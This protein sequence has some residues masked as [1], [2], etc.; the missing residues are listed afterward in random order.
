M[1]WSAPHGD[2]VTGAGGRLAHV[3]LRRT[4]RRRPRAAGG[5]VAGPAAR[6]VDGPALED[7][8][9]RPARPARRHTVAGGRGRA[10]PLPR[11]HGPPPRRRACWGSVPRRRSC[12]RPPGSASPPPCGWP[13]PS[14]TRSPRT[15]PATRG[16]L[17]RRHARCVWSPAARAVHLLRRRGLEALLRM[18]PEEVP[19]FFEVFFEL[20]EPHRWAYLTGRD[21]LAAT[22]A[23]MNALF[24]RAGW[25][26]RRAPRRPR[27]AAGAARER[28]RPRALPG[29]PAGRTGQRPALRRGSRARA[30][31][32][33]R[34]R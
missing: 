2:R 10:G 21:D 15:C 4:A 5:D 11:R 7:R 34:R 20:P 29:D 28:R 9:L 31:A 19:A 22:V 6:P 32:R 33:G 16:A 13:R 12:T 1:D 23:A 3:P 24:G 18:P 17:S 25:R 8:L 14:P 26:L 27:T 30:A